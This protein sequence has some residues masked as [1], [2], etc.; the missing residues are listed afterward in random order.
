LSA[1][2][3]LGKRDSIPFLKK[4]AWQSF[5]RNLSLTLPSAEEGRGEA[6]KRELV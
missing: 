5:K 2:G 6:K 3:A 4:D 1:S